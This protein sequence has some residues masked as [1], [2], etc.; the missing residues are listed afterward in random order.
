MAYSDSIGDSAQLFKQTIA[1]ALVGVVLN[2]A[3]STP[4]IA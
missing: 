1:S 2:F 3:M 4:S